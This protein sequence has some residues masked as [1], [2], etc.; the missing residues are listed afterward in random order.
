MSVWGAI[1]S[2]GSTLITS[3][4]ARRNTDRTNLANRELAEYAYS[5]DLEMWKRQNEYN[6]PKNQMKRF[7]EGGL[8][9]HL[10]YGQ[11]TPGNAAQ[12]PQYNA[13]RQDYNYKPPF[14]PAMALMQYQDYRQKNASIDLTKQQQL[15]SEVMTGLNELDFVPKT[16]ESRIANA[17]MMDIPE[18][19]LGK[20]YYRQD[21]I[22]SMATARY[23]Q[24]TA[25]GAISAYQKEV[26]AMRARLA[27]VNMTPQVQMKYRIAVGVLQAMGEYFGIP[28]DLEKLKLK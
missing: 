3:R 20:M 2:I 27:R 7:E 1:G 9:P 14:D 17:M 6:L 18:D 11:G 5:K 15:A 12:M 24:A 26:E 21:R 13:P 8:N 16:L 22:N 23:D 10:M 25:Q 4:T 28:V 19:G